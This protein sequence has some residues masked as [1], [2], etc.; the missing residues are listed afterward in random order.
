MPTVLLAVAAL[1]A[2]ASTFERITLTELVASSEA[3]VQIRILDTESRWDV[4]RNLIETFAD[5]EV[6]RT[7]RG[8]LSAGELLTLKEVGGEVDGYHQSAIGFPSLTAGD[9]L[10]VFLTHWD[11]G[12][13]RIQGY[14]AGTYRVVTEKGT[15]KHL[16]IPGPVQD[17][18]GN[19]AFAPEA[20]V[21]PRTAVDALSHTLATLK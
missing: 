4:Q 10:V 8:P 19:V 11:D 3:V 2:H 17:Q 5:V 21:A 18:P 7:L 20:P 9:N 6:A 12:S 1:S 15:G 13:W 14:G 16:L